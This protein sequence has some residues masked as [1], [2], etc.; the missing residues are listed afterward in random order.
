MKSKFLTSCLYRAGGGRLLDLFWG[1]TRLTVMAYHRIIDVNTPDFLYY[2]GVAE[3]PDVFARQMAYVAENF[4]VIDLARLHAFVK[5][6]HPLPSRPMLITFDDGYIDNYTYAFPLLRGLGLPAVIFLITG[7]MDNPIVP[8]WDECAYYFRRTEKS[9]VML[10]LLGA[11]DI[12]T[13]KQRQVVLDKLLSTLKTVPDA[14][15]Q[16]MIPQVSSALDVAPPP[17]DRSLFVSWD[18]VRE[19]VAN[20]IACQ[21]HTVS[22]PILTRVPQ[23][24]MRRQLKESRDRIISETGQEVM[25]FAYPNGLSADYDV[26]TQ[27]TVSSLGY[28]MAFTLATGPAKAEQVRKHPMTIPRILPRPNDSLEGFA[29]RVNGLELLKKRWRSLRLFKN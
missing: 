12:S 6:G 24:E 9:Q 25:A 3:S 17:H 5:H 4:N 18:Q 10:P 20:G 7:R 21:P 23:E 1:P 27:Q 26:T 8:W 22:H 29:L 2:D 28:S 14:D 19:M 15:K 11:Q 16:D 13:T